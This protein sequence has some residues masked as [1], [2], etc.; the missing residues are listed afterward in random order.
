MA[1]VRIHR[2]VLTEEERNRRIEAV[3]KALAEF[4][5]ETGVYTRGKKE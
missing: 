5:R 4:A 3:K 2:P 1:V